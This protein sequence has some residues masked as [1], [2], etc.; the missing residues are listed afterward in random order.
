MPLDKLRFRVLPCIKAAIVGDTGRSVALGH[1]DSPVFR[2]LANGLLVLYVVD[3][4]QSFEFVQNRHLTAAGMTPEDLHAAALSNFHEFI[5]ERTRIQAH[6]GVFAL[7][8]DGN[9]EASLL[10]VD[11]LW[12]EALAEYAPNGFV[13]V[14]PARDVLAFT[15]AGSASGVDELRDVVSRVF[16]CGDHTIASDLYCR[17]A[18]RWERYAAEPAATPTVAPRKAMNPRKPPRRSGR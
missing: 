13:V 14:V 11:S 17:E 2:D 6:G 8:L 16:P 12:D 15:D 9:F 3:A 18:G 7:F 10:L 5:A 1:A 4:G